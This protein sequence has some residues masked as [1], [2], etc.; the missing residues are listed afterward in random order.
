M[1]IQLTRVFLYIQ[2]YKHLHH[3]HRL[4]LHRKPIVPHDNLLKPPPGK[5]LIKL[6]KLG[7]LLGNKVIQLVDTLDLLIANGAISE[8][9]L[10][11]RSARLSRFPAVALNVPS[12][13]IGE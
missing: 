13:I 5:A 2:L 6:G 7:V 1:F 10:P 12:L 4:Q 3:N 9:F 8:V 11:S